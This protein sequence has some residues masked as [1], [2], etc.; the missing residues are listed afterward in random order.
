MENKTAIEK[1][2]EWLEKESWFM[3]DGYRQLAIKK[4]KELLA[5]I[6]NQNSNHGK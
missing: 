3:G 5:S 2:I 4:A 1:M 6:N